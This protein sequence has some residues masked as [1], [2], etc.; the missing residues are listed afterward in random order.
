MLEVTMKHNS[1]GDTRTDGLRCGDFS[2]LAC[3]GCR[4]SDDEVRVALGM[5]VV[6]GWVVCCGLV[7][8]S[9][10]C[11][12]GFV[13]G[14]CGSR[15]KAD[16]EPKKFN[17]L[18]SHGLIRGVGSLNPYEGSPGDYSNMEVDEIDEVLR[19]IMLT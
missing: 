14:G 3:C 17:I 19:A 6:V 1:G 2:F 11:G 15:L 10:W 9:R 8:A 7:D 18:H 12:L 4:F 13:G 16:L 5:A